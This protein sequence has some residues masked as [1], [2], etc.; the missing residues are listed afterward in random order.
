MHTGNGLATVIQDEEKHGLT[1]SSCAIQSFDEFGI[2]SVYLRRQIRRYDI[3]AAIDTAYSDV[4]H[5]H[6]R[7]FINDQFECCYNLKLKDKMVNTGQCLLQPIPCTVRH[8][9]FNSDNHDI[10]CLRV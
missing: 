6:N 5:L 3:T 4:Y 10:I 1:W 2:G 9:H 8:W 7:R